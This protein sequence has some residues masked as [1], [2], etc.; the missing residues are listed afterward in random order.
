MKLNCRFATILGTTA[1]LLILT[2]NCGSAQLD[3]GEGNPNSLGNKFKNALPVQILGYSQ[4]AMEPFLSPNGNYLFFNNSNAPGVNTNLYYAER[5]NDLT[6][7]YRGEL[8]NANSTAMDAVASIDSSGHFYFSST[9]NYS[10]SNVLT[11]FSAQFLNGALTT[12]PIAVDQGF[13]DGV[14]GHMNMDFS[15]AADGLT[16]YT[17]HATFSGGAG[18]D[19]SQLALVQKVSGTWQS[20]ANSATVLANVNTAS[21]LLYAPA[22]SA[23]GLNLYFTRVALPITSSSVTK[24]MVA[25]RANATAAFG[26]PELISA[27]A[28]DTTEAP[29]LT[30][31]GKRIYYHVKVG[32]VFKIY[33]VSRN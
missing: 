9:R 7:Q 25:T 28:G 12:A 2:Q 10:P 15:V 5:V 14:Y 21:A 32:G 6:F 29:T 8:T 1:A 13:S 4:D 16:G 24:I 27:I 19:T 22:I 11:I 17:S 20:S 30:Q 31:D 23:D 33:T 18:P 26:V 3:S